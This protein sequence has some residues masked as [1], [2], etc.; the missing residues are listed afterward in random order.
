MR[1]LRKLL[2]LRSAERN[3]LFK[4][5]PLIVAVRIA[6]WVLPLRLV[7]RWLAS[8]SRVLPGA[9]REGTVAPD[10]IGWAVETASRALPGTKNCLV[11]AV[12]TEALLTRYGSPAELRIGV[13]KRERGRLEAHAWIESS[14]KIVIG[15]TG[16]ELMTPLSART[17]GK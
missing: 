16:V 5:A 1:S 11:H 12:V 8:V 14:G 7:R 9:P 4:A 2:S 10:R 15:G 3:L 17:G 13:A 6:L